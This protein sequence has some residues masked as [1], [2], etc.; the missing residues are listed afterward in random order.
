M[1][2]RLLA[3]TAALSLLLCGCSAMLERDYLQITP[4]TTNPTAEGNPSVLKAE[5]YQELVNAL[6]HFITQGAE[7]GAV[8]LYWDKE[9]IESDLEKACLEV[10][11]EDPLGAYAVDYIKYS[12]NPMVSYS[13]ADVQIT[14]RRTRE[15]VAS[16]VSATGT[17]AIRSELETALA[18]FAPERV[19]RISYF[20]RD[21]EYIRTLCREAYLATPATALDMPEIT[22]SIYPDQ[23]RQRIVEIGLTYR[24]DGTELERR[25]GALAQTLQELTQPLLEQSEEAKLSDI[26]GLLADSVNYD[27]GS[28]ATAY[29]ALTEGSA[30]SQGLALALAALCESA[31]LNSQVVWG[32]WNERPHFWAVVQTQE[33]WRHLDPT[34][35]GIFF[36]TDNQAAEAGYSWIGQNIPVCAASPR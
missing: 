5:S 19:L 22:V 27:P 35:N 20:D 23:G 2:K 3:V 6:M 24:L 31:G 15:Q 17:A 1:K 9:T 30:N 34:E 16:I 29:H 32:E 28:G 21:E 10:I 26:L 7:T 11:Q 12:V 14:Y 36:G 8:R 18:A 4:H 25:R 13:E 33:G